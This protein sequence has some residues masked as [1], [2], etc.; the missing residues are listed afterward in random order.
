MATLQN[1]QAKIA[2]L[3]LQAE[4][5]VK[6]Q[7]SEVLEKIR[8]LME[9]HGVTT[10][11]IESYVGGKRRGRKASA[12]VTGKQST[13]GA[14]Y[15]D[16]KS[17]ATWTGHGRA[18]AWIAAAKDRNKFL[19]TDATAM[20]VLPAKNVAKTGNYVRGPQPPKYRDP[21][22]G[23]IWSGRGRAPAW[24]S[25]AKDPSKFL[26]AVDEVTATTKKPAAVQR[27][28]VAK[29]AAAATKGARQSVTAKAAP[30]GVSGEKKAASKKPSVRAKAPKNT[31]PTKRMREVTA[32]EAAA[33]SDSAAVVEQAAENI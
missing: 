15:R 16:P 2:K 26:I 28:T 14:K 9:R 23:A 5:I 7:T 3:Q 29:K 11:D 18:P 24:I 21:K 33:K 17:G 22:S 10:A 30:K 1:I 13:G 25:A 32:S 12:S 20:A 8:V 27:G 6:N 31:A 4:A 19:I